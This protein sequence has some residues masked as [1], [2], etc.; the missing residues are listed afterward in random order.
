M[1]VN[2]AFE[3]NERMNVLDASVQLQRIAAES[4]RPNPLSQV[5]LEGSDRMF[6]TK[7]NKLYRAG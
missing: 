1:P 2:F 6:S 3:L 4:E 5:A 7:E